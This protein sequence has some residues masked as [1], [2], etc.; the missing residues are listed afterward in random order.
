MRFKMHSVIPCILNKIIQLEDIEKYSVAGP[1]SLS[2]VSLFVIFCH[3]LSFFVSLSLCL[4]VSLFLCFFVGGVGRGGEG[5]LK[6]Y[7]QTSR[8]IDPSTKRVLEEHSLLK[9]GG[10]GQPFILK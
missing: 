7:I 6:F 8:H 4:F 1:L 5:K 2:R 10:R 9:S 3:F